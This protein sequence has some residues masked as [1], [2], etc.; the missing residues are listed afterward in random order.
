MASNNSVKNS[1]EWLGQLKASQLHRLAVTLGCACSGSKAIVAQGI[2]EALLTSTTP[3]LDSFD[4]AASTSGKQKKSKKKKSRQLSI[5]SIDMGIQNLA[6]AHLLLDPQPSNRTSKKKAQDPSHGGGK[7]PILRAWER[8]NVFPT[9]PPPDKPIR[10]PAHKSIAKLAAAA[11]YSPSRYAT[12]AYHF[13]THIL[14][15]CNPTHILIEQQRFRTGG[16]SAVAEWTLRVGVFEGM[17]HAILRT[18]REDRKQQQQQQCRV[19][20]VVSVSPARCA[21][22]WLEGGGY[23][24]DDWR[25]VAVGGGGGGGGGRGG[26][27]RRKMTGREGKQAKIDL[28]GRSFLHL[29]SDGSSGSS[30]VEPGSA[31]VRAMQLAFL[32]RWAV[33]SK[34]AKGLRGADGLI[35]IPPTTCEEG[36]TMPPIQPQKLDDL[37][38]CLLQALAWLRWQSMRDLVLRD[39]E[40]GDALAAVRRRLDGLA[41]D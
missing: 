22:F 25:A 19:E 20:E 7:L 9:A 38:D 34:A 10:K 17:L 29:G 16:S 24:S 28:V 35:L 31:Q 27:E 5:V 41:L 15:Q 18:V 32:Q 3:S 1:M 30:M 4:S 40:G 26:E 11:A 8:L 13:I 6:Y 2:R 12:A 14:A 21:R 33:T 23:A 39:C 37:A 36:A